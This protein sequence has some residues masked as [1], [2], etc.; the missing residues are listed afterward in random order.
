MKRSNKKIGGKRPGSGR[1]PIGV[2]KMWGV[3]LSTEMSD[4]VIKWAS[5]QLDRPNFS[6]AV[7]R[8]LAKALGL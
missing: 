3:K 4:A 2:D 8:L 1:K 6:E 5:K 7:R